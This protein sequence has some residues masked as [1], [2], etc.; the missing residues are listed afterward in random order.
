MF[1]EVFRSNNK[2]LGV[3]G[4]A[5]PHNLIKE[6]MQKTWFT[7]T[8]V[9]KNIYALA[10]F[11]HWEQVVSYLL[12]DRSN[13][14]LIDTGMG[15]E[16]I[17]NE[18]NKITLLPVT[19][20][21]THAHW[22]HIGGV[23]EFKKV[24]VFDDRFEK[25]SLERGFVSKEINELNKP[26]LFFNGYSPKEYHS[27]GSK[28]FTVI[29]EQFIASDNFN[30]QAIHTPGHTPGSVCFYI[31][32]FKVLFTGD[33]LYPGPLYAQLP[34]SNLQQYG[35]SINK[36]NKLFSSNLLILPGHNV[37][38]TQSKLLIDALQLF[39]ELEETS[40]EK[41]KSPLKGESLSL[42]F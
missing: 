26:I 3:W 21:L 2:L 4:F 1:G 5:E 7:V 35:K 42:I 29:K 33:T 22:D 30:I 13:A 18:V 20:L 16:S 10:E 9:H 15:Y 31:P 17:K 12:V 8:Q 27:L 11:S 23:T 25:A 14:F 39:Y 32:E 19:V 37:I 28:K 24:C 40:I 38:I 41:L 36:L 6:S 34:E